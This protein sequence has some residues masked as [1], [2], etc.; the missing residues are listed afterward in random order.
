MRTLLKINLSDNGE[1]IFVYGADDTLIMIRP[2]GDPDTVADYV[3]GEIEDLA[4]GGE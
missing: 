3:K 1:E 2:I 4:E